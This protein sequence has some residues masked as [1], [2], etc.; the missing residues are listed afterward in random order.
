[1]ILRLKFP[2]DAPVDFQVWI[3]ELVQ[4]GWVTP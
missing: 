1:M 3:S 4:A 2:P